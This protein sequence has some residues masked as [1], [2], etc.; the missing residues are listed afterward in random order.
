ML[1]NEG[2]LSPGDADNNES[3]RNY[4]NKVNMG[5]IWTMTS[6]HYFWARPGMAGINQTGSIN[7]LFVNIL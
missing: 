4:G 3:N 7:Y 1:R 2:W 6:T 5:E